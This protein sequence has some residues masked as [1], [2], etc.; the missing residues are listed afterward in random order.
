MLSDT[1]D[2]HS[3]QFKI[4]ACAKKSADHVQYLLNYTGP[5]SSLEDIIILKRNKEL[6]QDLK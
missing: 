4:M 6:Y 3:K 5:Y 1:F 2:A